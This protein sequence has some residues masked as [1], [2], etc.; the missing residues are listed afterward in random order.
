MNS[1]LIVLTLKSNNVAYCKVVE[2]LELLG[3]NTIAVGNHQFPKAVDVGQEIPL[4]DN[5]IAVE[6]NTPQEY[7]GEM[8]DNIWLQFIPA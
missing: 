6:R 7:K 4:P 3:E 5:R 8:R 2:E 1:K